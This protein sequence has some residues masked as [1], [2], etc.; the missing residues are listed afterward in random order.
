MV[1]VLVLVSQTCVSFTSNQPVT[2][3]QLTNAKKRTTGGGGKLCYLNSQMSVRGEASCM[4]YLN[5]QIPYRGGI[6]L[7]EFKVPDS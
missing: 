5:F 6:L 3:H 7:G 1:S 2:S 4:G